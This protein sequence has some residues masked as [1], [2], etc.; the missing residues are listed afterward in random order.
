VYLAR[1]RTACC[2]WPTTARAAAIASTSSSPAKQADLSSARHGSRSR[3]ALAAS[4]NGRSPGTGE[5]DV[6]L[7]C[8][9]D[10]PTLETVAA[11]ALLRER[12]PD[13]RVRVVNIVDLIRLQ[14]DIEH[15][16]GLTHGEFDA[17]FTSTSR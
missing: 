15:P 10:I 6:V 1:T 4:G 16:R 13:L 12:L 2:P 9:G 17:L 8:A 3:T 11:A 5:P 7:G 14:P